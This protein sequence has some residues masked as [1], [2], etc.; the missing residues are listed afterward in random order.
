MA[1]ITVASQFRVLLK[2]IAPQSVEVTRAK[3]HLN[4]IKARIAKAYP[5][6]RASIIGSHIKGTALRRLSDVDILLVLRR[7]AIRRGEG[8]ISSGTLLKNV[9]D[10]LRGRYPNTEIRRDAQAV[11]VRFGRG[12]H[13]VDV[14]PAI[15][16]A[17]SATGHPVYIIPNGTGGWLDTSPDGQLK[18]LKAADEKSGGK[19]TSV[20]RLMKWWM[21]S[22]VQWIPLDATHLESVVVKMGVSRSSAYSTLLSN[23]FR[24]LQGRAGSAIRDPIGISGLLPIASTDAQKQEVLS[25]V[26]Y[27]VD[28][29]L[30]AVE[31]EEDGNHQEAIRQWKIVFNQRFPG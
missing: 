13:G 27:A 6:A 14:V 23:V 22:R 8:F 2:N 31:A 29:S 19:L 28:H 20:I 25:A 9:R 26:R 7:D 11:A 1:P 4:G 3:R 12:E 17:P 15:F 21:F 10:E 18:T 5:V 24:T 16:G 30:R